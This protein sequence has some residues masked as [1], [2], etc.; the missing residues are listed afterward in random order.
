MAHEV[1]MPALGMAQDTG[2]LVSWLK[3]VGDKIS[4][5]DV[6][7]EVETDKT[8]MEVPAGADG[9]I[10][11]LRASPGQD[12]PVGQVI[13]VITAEASDL[14]AAPVAAPDSAP[15]VAEE[16]SQATKAEPPAPAAVP[17]PAAAAPRD[18]AG[19]GGRILASPK[20]KRRAAEA[21]L[22]LSRLAEAGVAQPY[23]VAD[24]E[25]LK[26]LPATATSPA[27]AYAPVASHIGA[28]VPAGGFDAFAERMRTEGGVEVT[29]TQT[30]VAFA[31]AGLRLARG[32]ESL[33][34]SS[35][36]VGVRMTYADPDRLRM[37]AVAGV[38]GDGPSDLEV[39]VIDSGHLT[40]VV[41]GGEAQPV[42]TITRN[43]DTF[44]LTLTFSDAT[45]AAEQAVEAMHALTRRLADPML[46]LI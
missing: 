15:V 45:L 19:A 12:V 28:E 21:G 26:N 17:A 24:V 35:T 29:L 39:R 13:A 36:L 38:E 18:Q 46:A 8:T 30:A 3:S 20:A 25:T 14:D 37:S 2:L 34:I 44:Y 6:L 22:D 43:A 11:E 4:A 5:D 7:M 23:R 1:I 10:A 41:L 40:T 9:F 32:G 16:L 31:A 33:T 42:L 27:M